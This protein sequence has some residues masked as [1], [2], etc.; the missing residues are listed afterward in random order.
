MLACALSYIGS[1]SS[2][3]YLSRLWLHSYLNSLGCLTSLSSIS[4]LNFLS[5]LAFRLRLRP[6]SFVLVF[7]R[8]AFL[9]FGDGH[10]VMKLGV[11]SELFCGREMRVQTCAGFDF[12]DVLQVLR[13][14]SWHQISMNM[15]RKLNTLTFVVELDP[16]PPPP[17]TPS[18]SF[19]QGRTDFSFFFP[20]FSDG[21]AW[22][23][24]DKST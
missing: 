7:F 23:P 6:K 14:N 18:S 1:L 22:R 11:I 16:P 2:V 15:H 9:H 10:S 17:H 3:C 8:F 13:A 20:F 19:S 21:L 12:E 4:S 24:R 5:L